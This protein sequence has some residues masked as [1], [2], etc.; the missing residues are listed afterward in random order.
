MG[1]TPDFLPPYASRVAALPG[2]IPVPRTGNPQGRRARLLCANKTGGFLFAP[3]G[4]ATSFCT[5]QRHEKR[6]R[7]QIIGRS[8][9]RC[10]YCYSYYSF[11][12]Y[13]GLRLGGRLLAAGRVASPGRA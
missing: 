2:C 13:H 8:V 11:S 12:S 4:Q 9:W 10:C 5:K 1:F 6:P 7:H 3:G